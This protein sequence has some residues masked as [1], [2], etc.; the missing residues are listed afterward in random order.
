MQSLDG[1]PILLYSSTSI[2]PSNPH[3]RSGSLPHGAPL[4]LRAFGRYFHPSFLLP[5][6]SSS[7]PSSFWLSRLPKFQSPVLHP[8]RVAQG[9]HVS[10]CITNHTLSYRIFLDC[11]I[12]NNSHHARTTSARCHSAIASSHSAAASSGHAGIS[13]C[14]YRARGDACEPFGALATVMHRTALIC[15][16]LVASAYGASVPPLI[17]RPRA[18]LVLHPPF[19]FEAHYLSHYTD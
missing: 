11:T 18:R 19:S 6:I 13:L 15:V 16:F 10:A 2:S 12:A 5:I 17:P 4:F 9:R 1:L 7:S 8:G 3:H 14:S